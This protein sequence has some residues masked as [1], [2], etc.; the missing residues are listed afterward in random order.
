MIEPALQEEGVQ[1]AVGKAFTTG[2]NWFVH[3][4]SLHHF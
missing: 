4:V 1:D 3:G 2:T